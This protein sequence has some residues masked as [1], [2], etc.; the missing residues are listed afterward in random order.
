MP[1]LRSWGSLCGVAL[2]L[3]VGCVGEPP[4]SSPAPAQSNAT[5]RPSPDNEAPASRSAA[6][7]ATAEA[8]LDRFVGDWIVVESSPDPMQE[9]TNLWVRREGD[10]LAIFESAMRELDLRIVSVDA[11][12]GEIALIEKLPDS[13]ISLA[14]K[15]LDE[16][17]VAGSEKPDIAMT[18]GDGTRWVLSGGDV[19]TG[20]DDY[21]NATI[22]SMREGGLR[23]AYR[24]ESGFHCYGK[25][26]FR[27]R[28]LC[29]D[30]TLSH[31]HHEL[32]S[33]FR[34]I[35]GEY[36]DSHRTYEAAIR[37]LDACEDRAC[38]ERQYADWS[39]YL[40]EN[41]EGALLVD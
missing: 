29:K 17:V 37:S 19:P 6:L 1:S 40:Q 2:V 28:T 33:K 39:R 26:G 14:L 8:R 5:G 20:G 10:K 11:D 9:Q 4:P 41:Y 36:P 32:M 31:R 24:V 34:S 22:A 35:S 12:T 18:W 38:L 30:E 15:P 3:A 23:L 13:E 21:S 25:I 27:Y 16:S 7:P